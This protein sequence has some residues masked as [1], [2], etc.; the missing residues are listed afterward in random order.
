MTKS[1]FE[2]LTQKATFMTSSKVT[3]KGLY[4]LGVARM[5]SE[6][7]SPHMEYIKS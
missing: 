6:K 5:N 4:D 7:N 1:T 2:E 3:T